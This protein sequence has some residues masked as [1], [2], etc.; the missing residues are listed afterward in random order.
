MW[1]D[2]L[3]FSKKLKED[4]LI[5]MFLFLIFNGTINNSN[6]FYATNASYFWQIFISRR[7][8]S[9]KDYYNSS[10][11]IDDNNKVFFKKPDFFRSTI[12]YFGKIWILRFNGWVI[13]T[14]HLYVP[15]I[16]SKVAVISDKHFI[17]FK[18]YSKL[19]EITLANQQHF[20]LTDNLDT[21]RNL[22]NFYNWYLSNILGN[23]VNKKTSFFSDLK[24]SLNII[25]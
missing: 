10:V 22:Y 19:T 2:K 8:L 7:D 16:R 21:Q 23:A 9:L 15:Q 25:Y 13:I 11:K 4:I 12:Y 1:D 5:N 24:T 18:K 20:C 3:N 17:F 6:F 14:F